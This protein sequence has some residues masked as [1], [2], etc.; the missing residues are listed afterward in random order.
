MKR[1]RL[2]APM[3]NPLTCCGFSVVYG[4]FL[5]QGFLEALGGLSASQ[6]GGFPGERLHPRWD[7]GGALDSGSVGQSL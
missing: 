3:Q 7:G 6:V 4:V 5:S 1:V 2:Q